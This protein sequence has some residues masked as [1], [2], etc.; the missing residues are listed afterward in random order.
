MNHTDLNGVKVA[1]HQLGEGVPII[2]LHGWGAS[3]ELV[4]PLAKR[5]IPRGYVA[6]VLDLPGHGD[7]PEPPNAWSV[8]EYTQLVVA[9]MKHQ[10]IARAHLFGHSFGGRISIVLGAT[11]PQLVDK[12]VLCDAAGIRPKTPLAKKMRLSAY[13]SLRDGLKLVG[14]RGLSDQLRGW[15]NKKYG[16]AD[17]LATSGIMRDTFLRV[18]NEDLSDYAKKISAPTLLI[19]GEKD[20]DTPLW[21]AKTLEKLIPDAG[22]V[23]YPNAGHYSYLEFPDQ[24]AQAM[25]AL[26]SA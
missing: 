12:I 1:Y 4:L 6:H 26:F 8:M 5:L 15:Y 9:Y 20:Q 2:M 14:L 3:A 21:Q 11:Y 23:V 25:H 10:N 18:V 19:W 22:L 17:F 16:S 7:S 13:K 24:T